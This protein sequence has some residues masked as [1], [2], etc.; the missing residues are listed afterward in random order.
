M[1]TI[2]ANEQK[3]KSA[4]ENAAAKI[5]SEK[6][7]KIAAEATAELDK[8]QPMVDAA[9]SAL[10]GLAKK[11]LDELKANK[12]DP[13]PLIIGCFRCTMI[14]LAEEYSKKKNSNWGK[15]NTI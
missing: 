8:A 4:K 2:D 7:G 6:A 12:K 11:D 14:M 3:E 1:A 10:D 5:A 9:K 13:N 15:K